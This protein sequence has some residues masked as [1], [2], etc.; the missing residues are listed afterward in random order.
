MAALG[1]EPT[2]VCYAEA[3]AAASGAGEWAPELGGASRHDF[4]LAL[5]DR[6]GWEALDAPTYNVALEIFA[7]T[8]VGERL[9]S[10]VTRGGPLL[11]S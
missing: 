11:S 7:G 2:P 3:L 10:Q 4:C 6:M 8:D 5:L 9:F 1:V